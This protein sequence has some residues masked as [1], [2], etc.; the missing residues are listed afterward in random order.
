MSKT[1]IDTSGATAPVSERT[2]RAQTVGGFAEAAA[3]IA[4]SPWMPGLRDQLLVN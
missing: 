4:G 2:Q 3:P 1:R